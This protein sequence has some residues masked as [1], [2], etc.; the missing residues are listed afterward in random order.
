MYI[1]Q[2]DII[3]SFLILG[4]QNQDKQNKVMVMMEMLTL[5]DYNMNNEETLTTKIVKV[6]CGTLAFHIILFNDEVEH[7]DQLDDADS[8]KTELPEWGW[9]MSKPLLADILKSIHT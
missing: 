9:V 1:N 7:E 6:K 8:V 2:Q 4:G 5:W 3:F